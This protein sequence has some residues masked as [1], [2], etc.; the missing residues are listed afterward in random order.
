MSNDL[1]EIYNLKDYTILKIMVKKLES[2]ILLNL[3][4]NVELALSYLSNIKLI[5]DLNN[6]EYVDSSGLSFLYSINKKYE[7]IFSSIALTCNSKSA[8]QSF[9]VF[10]MDKYFTVY[11]SLDEAIQCAS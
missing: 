7:S 11:N 1:F 3:K 5:I 8:L 9:S 6:V 10:E 4:D 2:N